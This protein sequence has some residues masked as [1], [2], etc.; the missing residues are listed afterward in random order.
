MKVC[1]PEWLA[2]ECVR[3]G[4]ILDPRHLLVVDHDSFDIRKVRGWLNSRVSSAT[5]EN[6]TAVAGALRKTAYWEFDNYQE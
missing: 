3:Q 5:G 6:W 1:S 2:A 4:G